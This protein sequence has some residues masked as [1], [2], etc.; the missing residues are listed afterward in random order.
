ME[1]RWK[2]NSIELVAGQG[3]SGTELPGLRQHTGHFEGHCLCHYRKLKN[4]ISYWPDLKSG[5]KSG[6]FLWAKT[7]ATNTAKAAGAIHRQL[8]TVTRSL[9]TSEVVIWSLLIP[10]AKSRGP[11]SAKSVWCRYT[12]VGLGFIACSDRVSGC[13]RRDAEWP[14]LRGSFRQRKWERTLEI[15]SNL[16]GQRKP[17]KL[18]N[19]GGGFRQGPGLSR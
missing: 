6:K 2:E 4:K 12:V 18:L 9:P 13:G 1:L 15:R 3:D 19:T 10:R 14:Q 16:A 17:H 5:Q 11:K 7:G 8:S